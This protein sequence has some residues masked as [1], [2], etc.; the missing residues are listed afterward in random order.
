MS[1]TMKRRTRMTAAMLMPLVFTA[2]IGI[3]IERGVHD[4]DA[5]FEKAYREIARIERAGHGRSR[6]AHRL[7][8]LIRDAEEDQII[9]LSVPMWIVNACLDA[10][11]KASDDGHEYDARK[12]YD[13]DWKAV[14]DLGQYGPGLL[15]AVE[16]ERDKVLIWLK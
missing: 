6:R 4:A 3:H 12:H 8:L 15:V 1:V 14:K 16:E 5:Y 9:R 2:C 10:G 13:L 7:C 11:M